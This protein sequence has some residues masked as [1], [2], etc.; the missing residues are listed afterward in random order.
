MTCIGAGML[1]FGLVRPDGTY[2]VDVLGPSMVTALGIGLSFVPVTIAATSGVARAEAGLASGLVNTSRQVGGS[3][4]L[5]VLATLAQ[6]RTADLMRAGA[7]ASD[8]ADRG[9]PPRVRRRRRLRPGRARSWRSPSSAASRARARA[10]RPPR[11]P[12]PSTR[13]RRLSS[14]AMPAQRARCE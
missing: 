13:R 7:G 10:A 6:G 11:R 8:G 4:G 9:L 14:A 3:L 12:T 2:L 1:L 5:A